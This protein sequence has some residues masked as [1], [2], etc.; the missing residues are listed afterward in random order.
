VAIQTSQSAASVGGPSGFDF[1]ALFST[2]RDLNTS[3]AGCPNTVRLMDQN[4]QN[5]WNGTDPNAT[6]GLQPG[7]NVL[8]LTAAEMSA[9]D[10]I[11]PLNGA[12]QPGDAAWLVINVEVDGDYT[13][14]VPQVSWQGNGPS[15]HVLELHHDRDDH[16]AGRHTHGVGHGLRAQRRAGGQQQRQHRRQRRGPLAEPWRAGWR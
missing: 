7:Q 8:T 2:Y 9:L 3:I 13:W 15:R 4:G 11:N 1:P 16:L 12:L 10:N 14:P 6:I 5:P